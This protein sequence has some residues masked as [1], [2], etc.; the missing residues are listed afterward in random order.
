VTSLLQVGLAVFLGF[1]LEHSSQLVTSEGL[2]VEAQHAWDKFAADFFISRLV[3]DSE[4]RES[5]T[6]EFRP[7]HA[8]IKRHGKKYVMVWDDL[9]KGINGKYGFELRRTSSDRPWALTSLVLRKGG[10]E[11]KNLE[12]WV[13]RQEVTTHLYALSV[14]TTTLNKLAR[15]E[16]FS[17]TRVETSSEPNLVDLEFEI[18]D[19]L[20]LIDNHP[21]IIKR[22]QLALD[23][24]RS[25]LPVRSEL[26][27]VKGDCRIFE[28][29]DF[30]N[31]KGVNYPSVMRGTVKEP[32]GSEWLFQT[33][34]FKEVQIGG[35]VPDR[36][37][38]L[39][40]FGLAEPFDS[41]QRFPPYVWIAA[42]A[43]V[44]IFIGVFLRLRARM[45]NA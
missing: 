42:G 32:D 34:T 19:P 25:W 16:G 20:A 7:S 13:S 35:S 27:T 21:I 17:V 31:E 18:D 9:V 44:M 23:Q 45:R 5:S 29:Q 41:P 22:G 3:L 28:L 15:H 36:E 37:F 10:D 2:P 30:R 11:L 12:R 38:T 43:G 14:I 39:T 8:T 24:S 4:L 26:V 33:T 40:Y 1:F 6:S